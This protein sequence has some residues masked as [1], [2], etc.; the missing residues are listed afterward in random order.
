MHRVQ[1]GLVGLCLLWGCELESQRD[2]SPVETAP[3][4]TAQRSDAGKEVESVKQSEAAESVLGFVV[5]DI[6]GNEVPLSRYRG[7]VLLIVNVASRCGLTPQYQD[8]QELHRRYA[9]QGLAILGFPANEFGAQEPG[10]NAEIKQFCTANY[11][12]EFD[13][14][15][16]VVV[17]GDGQCGLY[18]F[19]TSD[20]RNPGYGGEIRWNFTKFL[21]DREGKVIARFEPRTRPSDAKVAQAIQRAL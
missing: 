19:L 9:D 20:E 14:F 10:T 8:L 16:K 21:V 15:A 13:M 7:K 2:A 18:S 12:V 1:I 17:K 6:D 11:G 3:A 5:K 4:A